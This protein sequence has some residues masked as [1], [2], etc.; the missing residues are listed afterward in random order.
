MLSA[1][2]DRSEHP[3]EPH[4]VTVGGYLSDVG[5]W[6]DFDREWKEFLARPEYSLTYF[7]MKEFTVSQKAFA[8][9]W[10]G[11][12]RKRRE[13]MSGLVEIIQRNTRA[14][15]AYSVRVEEFWD[16]LASF[17]IAPECPIASPYAYCG[18]QCVE[19][20]KLA[21][22]RDGYNQPIIRS[23]FEDGEEDEGMLRGLLKWARHPSPIFLPKIPDGAWQESDCLRPLQAADLV[24]WEGTKFVR[25]V[26]EN[27]GTGWDDVRESFKALM[28][29]P[30]A[31]W[32]LIQKDA[33][34]NHI[35]QYVDAG[36]LGRR[37]EEL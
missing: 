34:K 18:W 24:A 5:I 35:R 19:G 29:Y 7:H 33:I 10:K 4:I 37:K 22:I 21:A 12:H 36:H 9:G 2:Y 3:N 31:H 17:P 1:Y 11:E 16:A 25:T 23:F 26:D 6:M 32:G 30:P 27:D 8:N 20:A 14:S 13:F 28:H 15:F